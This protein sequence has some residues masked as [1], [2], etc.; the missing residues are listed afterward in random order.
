MGTIIGAEIFRIF[1]GMSEGPGDFLSSSK[2][3]NGSGL[4]GEICHDPVA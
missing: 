2:S 1:I 4:K 3:K